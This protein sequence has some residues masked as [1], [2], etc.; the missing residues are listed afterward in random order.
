MKWGFMLAFLLA[1]CSGS[2]EL[3][4]GLR[5]S[6]PV[7]IRAPQDQPEIV[8][9]GS[10]T[11]IIEPPKAMCFARAAHFQGLVGVPCVDIAKQTRP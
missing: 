3:F 1:G 9:V 4:P 10:T 5:S 2:I 11:E 6:P 8:Q 7:E